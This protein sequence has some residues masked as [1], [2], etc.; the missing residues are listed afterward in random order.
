LDGACG[1]RPDNRYSLLY[2]SL[3]VSKKVRL[4]AYRKYD[5]KIDIYSLGVCIYMLAYRRKPYT[6]KNSKDYW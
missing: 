5:E 1:P 6:G 2:G 4:F 3:D